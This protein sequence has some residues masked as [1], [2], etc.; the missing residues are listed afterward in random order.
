MSGLAQEYN[1]SLIEFEG[2]GMIDGDTFPAS[3]LIRI[4]LVPLPSTLKPASLVLYNANF[5]TGNERSVELTRIKK[6]R[7]NLTISWS[8]NF[9]VLTIENK[10]AL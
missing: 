3:L 4:T 5:I 7:V 8:A 1:Q 10:E 6:I 9:D 2:K